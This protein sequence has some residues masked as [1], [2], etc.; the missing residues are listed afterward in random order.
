MI[1]TNTKERYV[2]AIAPNEDFIGPLMKDSLEGKWKYV[3]SF[4]GN[5]TGFLLGLNPKDRNQWM[6][7][8]KHTSR[9]KFPEILD[10]EYV[11]N[12]S[13]ARVFDSG[14]LAHLFTAY[15]RSFFPDCSSST[16]FSAEKLVEVGSERH[17][18]NC[19]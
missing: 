13:E 8:V 6:R 2:V 7:Y 5:L 9:D 1:H 4:E 19:Y 12:H 15:M 14:A 11:V 17:A 16:V 10:M 3:K 18:L